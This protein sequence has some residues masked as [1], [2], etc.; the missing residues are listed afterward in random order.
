MSRVLGI[1]LGGTSIK[2]GILQGE[3][4][5]SGETVPT[6]IEKGTVQ[7]IDKLAGIVVSAGDIAGVGIGV[8]GI[9]DG[10]RRFIY[11][12][13]N[14][15]WKEI[16]LAEILE[17][18]TGI[19]V[20]LDNDA[21]LA[22]LAEQQSGDLKGVRNGILLTL[23]TG[24]GGGVI[25]GGDLYRGSHGLGFEVGHMRIGY[26][27]IR[28]SC[29]RE[30]CFEVYSSATGLLRHYNH[31]AA[32]P[33]DQAREV[34]ASYGRREAV[35][36]RTM[37]W[38]LDHLAD[39]VVNLINLFDPERIVFAGG[40]AQGLDAVLEDLEERIELRK[41]TDALPRARLSIS[42]LNNEAGILGGGLLARESM[43]G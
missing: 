2:Y 32:L 39:G 40:V 30:D 35:G 5:L 26:E 22:T 7:L 14:L 9:V 19:P 25:L 42:A 15:F 1:D 18:R 21:N 28:C 37:N 16:P 33:V 43:K 31:Q 24:V 13:K 41:F 4:I 38:Y 23:G 3:D 36:I 17:K 20:V 12:C 27:G 8:P 34:F 10:T 6:E 11:E 29:G